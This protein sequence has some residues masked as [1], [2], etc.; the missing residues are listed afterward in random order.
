MTREDRWD[1]GAA[2]GGTTQVYAGVIGAMA[3][4]KRN[5]RWVVEGRRTRSKR[6]DGRRQG[7]HVVIIS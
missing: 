5:W 1:P 3:A 4:T 7:D 6:V 2:S